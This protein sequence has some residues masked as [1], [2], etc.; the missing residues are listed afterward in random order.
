VLPDSI[1]LPE[2]STGRATRIRLLGYSGKLK[3]KSGIVTIPGSFRKQMESTPA[4]VFVI[5]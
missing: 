4:L 1:V 2:N 3:I 5:Y